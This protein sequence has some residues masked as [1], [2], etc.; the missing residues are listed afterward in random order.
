MDECAV[1]L[2]EYM[3]DNI[4]DVIY[5][6]EINKEAE[7]KIR[8]TLYSQ[9]ALFAFGYALGKLWMSW[10]IYPAAFVGHSIGEFVSAYF[11]GIY[12]LKDALRLVATRGRM[13]GDLPGGSM[14]SVRLSVA[15]IQQF[16]S[17]EVA[18]AAVNSPQLCVVAG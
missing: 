12:S 4:L 16:L 15:D 18:L 5:P 13:M 10:G 1:I 14:L 2:Q 11:S 9:P 8:N 6:N 7:E 17:D 3:Q